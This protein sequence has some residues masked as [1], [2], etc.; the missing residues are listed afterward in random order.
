MLSF[1][2]KGYLTF[3]SLYSDTRPHIWLGLWT[4]LTLVSQPEPPPRLPRSTQPTSESLL[5]GGDTSCFLDIPKITLTKL[6]TVHPPIHVPIYI[7][8][9]IKSE[10]KLK[11]QLHDCFSHLSAF[12]TVDE[13]RE[14]E[15]RWSSFNTWV[16]KVVE[17]CIQMIIFYCAKKQKEQELY[18]IFF[19]ILSPLPF[20][21]VVPYLFI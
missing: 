13:G 20:Q 5:F 7:Q 8:S 15:F 12:L 6:K 11:F 3:G 9:I 17:K 19:S 4:E 18:V 2:L 14:W 21:K 10:A 16:F 1:F